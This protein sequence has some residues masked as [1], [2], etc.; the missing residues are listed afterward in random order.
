[1]TTRMPGK[2]DFEQAQVERSKVVDYLLGSGTFASR[3]K[4]RFFLSIEFSAGR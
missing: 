2:P 4:A 3:A 1:M